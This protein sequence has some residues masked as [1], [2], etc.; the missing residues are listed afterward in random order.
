MNNF[1]GSQPGNELEQN[2]GQ[3]W[4]L[5]VPNSHKDNL[6]LGGDNSQSMVTSR[7]REG[8]HWRISPKILNFYPAGI[9][10]YIS[11]LNGNRVD[12]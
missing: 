2:G 9:A 7:D 10:A 1:T 5:K 6:K 12:Y 11:S 4:N 8:Y 3:I